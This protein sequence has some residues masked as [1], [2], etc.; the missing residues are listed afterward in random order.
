[1]SGHGTE[2]IAHHVQVRARW[3]SE[4]LMPRCSTDDGSEIATK[5]IAATPSS[6]VRSP[7]GG[8][9]SR[10]TPRRDPIR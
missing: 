1:M 9:R 2:E 7:S 3:L 5:P 6:N 8:T 4:L 10:A